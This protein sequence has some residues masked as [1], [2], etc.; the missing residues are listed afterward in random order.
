VAAHAVVRGKTPELSV[1]AGIPA[2][3]V[4]RRVQGAQ[5]VQA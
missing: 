4:R 5:D 3:V 1:L 2:K